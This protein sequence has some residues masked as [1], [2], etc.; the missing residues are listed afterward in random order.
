MCAY[1]DKAP[2]L[3]MMFAGGPVVKQIYYTCAQGSHVR[4]ASSR[5]EDEMD[6]KPSSPTKE[7]RRT[8]CGQH[9]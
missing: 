4:V 5:E 1:I 6:L 3:S 2:K 7:S 9:P 8:C